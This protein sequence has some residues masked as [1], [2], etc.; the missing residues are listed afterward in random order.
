LSCFCSNSFPYSKC[1]ENV[2]IPLEINLDLKAYKNVNILYV[3][4]LN[5]VG[6]CIF[7]VLDFRHYGLFEILYRHRF[8]KHPDIFVKPTRCYNKEQLYEIKIQK[9]K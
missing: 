9:I 1:I 8:R 3:L 4:F 2:D 5:D 7:L 6:L